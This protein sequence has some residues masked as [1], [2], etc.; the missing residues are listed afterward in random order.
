MLHLVDIE[1]CYGPRTLLKGVSWHIPPNARIGLVGRNGVGKSTLFGIIMDEVVLDAGEV[2]RA[3]HVTIGHLAQETDPLDDRPVIEIVLEAATEVRAIETEL[4]EVQGRITE[5][6]ES[7]NPD[8]ELLARYERLQ[9]RFQ[10]LGGYEIDSEARRILTGLGF[11]AADQDSPASTFSGG[12]IMRIALAQ[13]LL[14]KPDLLL[15][16]EPTNHL[17]LETL[18]WFEGFLQAY[19]GTVVVISHD[20]AMLNRVV[21]RIA[22]VTP[23]GV[24]LYMG[25]YDAYLVERKDRREKQTATARNQQKHVEEQER[26]IERFRYKNTKAKAVQSRIKALEKLERIY[27]PD[28]EEGTIHLRFPQPPRSGKEVAIAR[29]V[30][31]FYGDLR[32][33]EHLDLTLFRGERIALVGPN[34]AGKSTLLKML[35]GVLEPTSGELRLGANVERAYFAQHQLEALDGTRTVLAE[36]ES[37]ADVDNHPR[38]RSLLGAF[39]FSGEDVTKKV[40]VLSGGEKA[41]LALAKMM[42]TPPNLLLLD[43]PTNHLDIPTRDL[44]QTAIADYEGTVV[45]ISHDRHFIDTVATCV[46]EVDG[47]RI[48]RFSGGYTDYGHVRAQRD[49]EAAGAQSEADLVASSQAPK[50]RSRERKRQEAAQRNEHHR[51]VKPL[52]DALATVERRIAEVE[53]ALVDA[54][55]KMVDPALFEDATAMRQV[56]EAHAAHETEHATLLER[57]ETLGTELEEADEAL[58][59]TLE[60]AP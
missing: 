54:G 2:V 60:D 53:V 20:R 46:I 14:A 44:L 9:S 4:N 35:A 58:R 5:E 36:M 25:G 19:S 28:D 1:K 59:N 18:L 30:A 43:E 12:W 10:V 6:A 52:K 7:G 57:W 47:G 38:C 51:V 23:S 17:D 32:V 22:E 37:I 3:K 33:Y 15:L 21:D 56:Y 8:P 45:L 55:A 49:R 24:D 41:R 40:R 39:R 26:F 11:P 29:D 27:A 34:G 31:K 13:L 42:L 50:R 16:D 48:E